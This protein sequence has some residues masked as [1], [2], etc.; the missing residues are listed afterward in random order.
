MRRIA[1][2]PYSHPVTA[3]MSRLDPRKTPQQSRSQVTCDA[4]LEAAARILETGG[5]EH[6]TTNHVAERAGVSVGS[7][8]QYFPGKQAIIAGLIRQMRQDMLVD[9]QEAADAARGRD[10][11]VVLDAL[12]AASLRHHLHR[13][14]L[15]EALERAEADLRLDDEIQALKTR[16]NALIVAALRERGVEEPERTAFD[17]IALSRGIAHAATSAG[18]RDFNDLHQRMSRA[19]RGYLGLPPPPVIVTKTE[20]LVGGGD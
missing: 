7:L 1:R 5:A 6:L 18:E 11:A 10:L 20:P 19:A 12:I 16:M 17:L 8:Y 14:A 3:C 13:P 15:A 4:I 9:F 2:F